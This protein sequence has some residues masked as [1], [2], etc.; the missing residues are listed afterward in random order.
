MH[1]GQS[2]HITRTDNG[3]PVGWV[4]AIHPALENE[5]G[6]TG[7]VFLFELCL[8]AIGEA[9][10]PRFRELSKYPAIR[11]DIAL[12]VDEATSAHVVRACITD[13]AGGL[14][15]GLLQGVQLFDVYRGKGVDPGRKSL[16]LGLT[17]QDS[18]RTLTDG[19]IDA[20]MEQV[21]NKLRVDLGAKLRD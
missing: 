2:A 5:L 6:L 8:A 12:I 13:A 3:E 15:R 21:V 4:G 18:S 17:W 20:L 16:A 19:D 14:L 7:R 10:L 1:P 9:R 11:R